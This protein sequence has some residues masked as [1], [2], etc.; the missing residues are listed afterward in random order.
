[1][2][3]E[4]IKQSNTTNEL[5][6]NMEVKING[7]KHNISG[8]INFQDYIQDFEVDGIQIFD[9]CEKNNLDYDDLYDYMTGG[10]EDKNW[11]NNK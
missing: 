3:L 1:M 8:Y 5:N 9:F 11:D 10:I 7:V 6:V 4:I 2:E